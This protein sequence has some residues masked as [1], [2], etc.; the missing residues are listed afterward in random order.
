MDEGTGLL[1]QRSAVLGTSKELPSPLEPMLESAFAAF[2]QW[3]N[4]LLQGDVKVSRSNF[5]I[6]VSLQAKFGH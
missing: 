3:S 4:I 2:L 6:L 5:V 1:S